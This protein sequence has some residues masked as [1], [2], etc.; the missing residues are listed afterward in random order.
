MWE[1]AADDEACRALAHAFR[2]D[3]QPWS[4]GATYP[5]FLGDEGSSRMSAAFG[6]SAARLE[7]LWLPA[8]QIPRGLANHSQR[9]LAGSG[10]EALASSM[11]RQP[12]E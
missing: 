9:I 4:V 7:P 11:K 10:V 12:L 1:D 2:R 3:V 5:N 6:A 8:R